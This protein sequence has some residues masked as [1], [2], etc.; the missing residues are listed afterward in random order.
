MYFA[1]G[2]LKE[3]IERNCKRLSDKDYC[4]PII[5]SQNP[6]WPGDWQGRGILALTALYEATENPIV[7]KQL[8]DIINLLEDNVNEHGYFGEIIDKSC[9]N[10]QQL[11]G[12]GW[13][14]RSLCDYYKLTKDEKVLT[15]LQK[16]KEKL[17][18]ELEPSY[19]GY[20]VEK[21]SVGGVSGHVNEE[22]VG[23]WK[24]SSDIGCAFILLDGLTA[25]CEILRES[26]L[27]E[28]AKVLIE[29]FFTVDFL[30]ANFQTHAFLTATRAI[31]RLYSITGDSLYLEK[32]EQNFKLYFDLGT[33]VNYANFNWF[34]KP[35]SWTEPCAFIDSVMV[36]IELF[37]ITGKNQ[38]LAFA[39]RV[40]NN[41]FRVAQRKNGGAG[42]E[43]CLYED[44][45]E[46]TLHLYEAFFCCTMRFADG[47]NY[48]RKNL[49]FEK[50]NVIFALFTL[51]G[52]YKSEECEF[53][54]VYDWQNS[55]VKITV[56]R[57]TV[58][59]LVLY[60][61]QGVKLYKKGVECEN[62][63]VGLDCGEHE[64]QIKAEYK[65]EI[66]A[67]TSAYFWSDFLL[68][69]KEFNDE[70]C[71]K[72]IIDGKTYSPIQDCISVEEKYGIE[73]FK[74]RI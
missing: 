71:V 23:G 45:G 2:D 53:D 39:N 26:K 36:A 49:F 29:K 18:Y 5:F 38:Y 52:K 62:S 17:F 54:Y 19:K 27:I 9:I 57:G 13:F 63:L 74:Q 20:T 58:K 42:C 40:Y 55:C 32:S 14:V 15:I 56:E 22:N 66:M 33:T 68:T 50:D 34:G 12:N 41:A 46:L 6:S 7:L 70:S 64:Y 1:T 43:K 65:K 37:K 59:N 4:A 35:T 28:I 16:I 8:Q 25:L 10:E 21:L 51:G 24:H 47:L 61:P 73:N 3:R 72:F 11:S 30:K 60:L 48:L 67:K 44:N 69:Q 31:L